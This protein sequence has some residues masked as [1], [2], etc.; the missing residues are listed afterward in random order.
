MPKL[1][2][3]QSDYDPKPKYERGE[4]RHYQKF[5]NTKWW[6]KVRVVILSKKPI[7]VSCEAIGRTTRATDV[8]HIVPHR[9]K[10]AI[11]R[12]YSNLQ[13]LCKA[14]H[15]KKTATEGAFGKK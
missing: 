12:D 15:S 7:C 11:F 9:G 4:S 1:P 10:W 14:C 3:R 13:P 6:R 8:D 5:Y 2:T